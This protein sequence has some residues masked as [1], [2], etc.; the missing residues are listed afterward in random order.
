METNQ[1]MP[2]EIGKARAGC[3]AEGEMIGTD[4][5]A[6]IRSRPSSPVEGGRGG[7]IKAGMCVW[8]RRVKEKRQRWKGK[9][10]W[11]WK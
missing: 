8:L 9:W 6:R 2:G 7:G 3:S 10:K 5:E 11:K 4:T 1:G